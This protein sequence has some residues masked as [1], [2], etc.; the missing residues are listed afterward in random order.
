MSP[1]G[2]K[3]GKG[4]GYNPPKMT[5]EQFQG[6]AT[7]FK[8]YLADNPIIKWSI[9]AAGIAGVFETAHTLWLLL[10]WLCGRLPR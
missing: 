7:F 6:L 9:I 4:G 10:V 2:P 5:A 8:D 1:D 3:G